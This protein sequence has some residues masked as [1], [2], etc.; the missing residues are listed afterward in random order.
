MRHHLPYSFLRIFLFGLFSRNNSIMKH[1][2]PANSKKQQRIASSCAR[3]SWFRQS[4][5]AAS[6]NANIAMPTG[7]LPSNLQIVKIGI[8][9]ISPKY[10]FKS[11]PGL[12][13]ERRIKPIVIMIGNLCVLKTFR[14]EFLIIC[15][16][17]SLIRLQA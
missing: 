7:I 12:V 14:N 8:I 6:T 5:T 17:Y 2:I 16:I 11:F 1:E 9:T 4:I 10:N 15:L 13:Q 3:L